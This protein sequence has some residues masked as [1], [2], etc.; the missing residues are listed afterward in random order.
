MNTRKTINRRDFLKVSALGVASAALLGACGGTTGGSGKLEIFSWWTS[1]GEVEAL[2]GLY[3]VFKA[4]YPKVEIVNSAISGGTASGGD[5][6]AVLQTRMMGGDPPESFQVHLGGELIDPYLVNNLL[7]P[8]DSIYESEGFKKVFPK[9]VIDVATY[10]GKLYAVP[11]NI[12]RANVL[13]YNTK[14]LADIGAKPPATWED[15]LTLGEKFKAKNLPALAVAENAPG[16]YG[17]VTET[18][19]IQ[20][21]GAEKWAGLFTGATAWTDPA[22]KQGLTMALKVLAYANPNYLSTAWGDVN[23][24]MIGQKVAMMVQGDWTPG[25]FWSKKFTDFGWADAPGNPNIYQ[26]LS[27]SFVLPK[28]VK[29]RDA[30]IAFL[31]ICGSKEGQDA[32]NPAKGSIPARTDADVSKYSEYQKWALKQWASNKIIPSVVHGSAS[33]LSFMTDYMNIV[34]QLAAKKTDVDTTAANLVKAAANANFGK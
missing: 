21:M 15:F 6:K 27:D 12:H 14:M 19:I 3:N 17:Q 24:L 11:V 32:F 23:D 29:N 20:Y 34:N 16:F 30:A 13:W 8:V 1:G 2:N 4:K 33:K 28:K 31:K 25:V 5:M 18:M 7:E 26:A 22:I 9:G 10:K